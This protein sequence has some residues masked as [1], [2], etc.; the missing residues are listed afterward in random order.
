MED[1]VI[2]ISTPFIKLEALLK[3]AGLTGTGGEAK[4][5]IQSGEV[6]VNGEICLQRGRKLYDGDRVELGKGEKVLRVSAPCA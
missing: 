6:S 3:F 2:K 5:R 4:F 1:G